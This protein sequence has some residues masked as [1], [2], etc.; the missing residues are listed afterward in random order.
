[1]LSPLDNFQTSMKNLKTPPAFTTQFVDKITIGK[2]LEE[3]EK[4]KAKTSWPSAN[5]LMQKTGEENVT[6]IYARKEKVYNGKTFYQ[7]INTNTNWNTTP[8]ERARIEEEFHDNATVRYVFEKASTLSY[9]YGKLKEVF[10]YS[11]AINIKDEDWNYISDG[12]KLCFTSKRDENEIIGK[13][14]ASNLSK[15]SIGFNENAPLPETE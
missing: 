5:L 8:E 13:W 1:M 15:T 14:Y 9:K 2:S 3:W 6:R 10:C 7:W 11:Q 4:Y 12:T